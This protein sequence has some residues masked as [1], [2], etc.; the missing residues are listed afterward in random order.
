V[1]KMHIFDER[2]EGSSCLWHRSDERLRPILHYR[3][4]FCSIKWF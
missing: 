3:K 4:Y 2:C 1:S